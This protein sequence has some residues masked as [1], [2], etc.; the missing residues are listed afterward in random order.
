MSPM[1]SGR[2]S[3]ARDQ[4]VALDVGR[5]HGVQQRDRRRRVLL[6][7]RGDAG[8][9]WERNLAA[10]GVQFAQDQLEQ[11]GFAHAVAAHQAD[12]GARGQGDGGVVEEAASPGV[13]DE[14]LDLKHENWAE[15]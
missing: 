14:V 9:F 6:V 2:P 4:G 7:H 1:R 8:R 11:G 10:V 12:L 13:E 15:R 3:P 5:Q